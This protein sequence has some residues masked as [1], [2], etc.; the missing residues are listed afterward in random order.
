MTLFVLEPSINFFW[1]CDIVTVTYVTIMCDVTSQP[2]SQVWIRK[3]KV[4]NKKKERKLSL[5]F[6]T[7]T[8]SSHS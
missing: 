2:L 8:Y 6:A 7:L 3:E 5:L 4:K 1:S